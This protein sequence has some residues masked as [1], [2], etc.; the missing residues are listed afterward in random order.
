VAIGAT[1]ERPVKRP[2]GC[3]NRQIIDAGDAQA[4]QAI[5]VEF[6]I[7]IAIAAEPV[8]ELSLDKELLSQAF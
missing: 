1:A 8:S 7:L 6:P 5:L 2:L 4:H 3:T